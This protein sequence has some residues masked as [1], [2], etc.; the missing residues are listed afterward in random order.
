MDPLTHTLT[1]VALSRAGLNRWYPPGAAALVVA[2]AIPDIDVVTRLWGSATNLHYHRHLTHSLVMMPVMA[3]VA[4]LVVALVT[5]RRLNWKRAWAMALIGVASHIAID[6]CNSYGVRPF[7]PFSDRWYYLD[8]TSLYDAWI[9][10]V[11]LVAA[12]APALAR[13]VS[14][15]IG[16]RPGSGRGLA[17]FALVF[18]VGFSFY[19]YLLHERA[20]AVLESRLYHG[21]APA[22]VAAFPSR[23]S[24]W[25]WN[26]LVETPAFYSLHTINLNAE[27][28]PGSGRLLYKPE[29]GPEE[30]VAWEAARQTRDFQVF[31]RFARFPFRRFERL[32]EPEPGVRV[33]VSELRFGEPP[34]A[35]FTV[36]AV[37]GPDGR[38]RESRF[39]FR[40][41]RDRQTPR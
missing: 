10:A 33:E 19:R 36:V 27:F 35:P 3:L 39:A 23:V 16:A 15:E 28:D 29:L 2:A 5:S 7:L 24:P 1:G 32:E 9:W 30:A 26:G 34:H 4:V 12:L 13:L 17:I 25:R 11:L 41:G 22:R 8:I 14:S 31:L 18:F 21:A 6:F 40:P 20:V 38:V 37:V